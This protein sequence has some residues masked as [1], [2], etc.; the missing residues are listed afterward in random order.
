MFLFFFCESNRADQLSGS[1]Q[2]KLVLVLVAAP[3]L[4][5]SQA[6]L[7]VPSARSVRVGSCRNRIVVWLDM[8]TL[9]GL[10]KIFGYPILVILLP[11]CGG[12]PLWSGGD[13][14]SDQVRDSSLLLVCRWCTGAVVCLGL[15]KGE[16]GSNTKP[17]VPSQYTLA[18]TH[19]SLGQNGVE[20][21]TSVRPQ[22]LEDSI[23]SEQ[24]H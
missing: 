12:V 22:R 18:S 2:F 15:L 9:R 14:S 1:P 13:G 17:K 8:F 23:I 16:D 19:G 6:D 5:M 20:N 21:G 24:T 4:M 11:S 7:G 10:G 3:A